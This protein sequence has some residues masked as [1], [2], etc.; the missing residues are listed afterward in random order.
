MPFPMKKTHKKRHS[1]E[2]LQFQNE[3]IEKVNNA[4]DKPRKNKLTKNASKK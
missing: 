1:K 4:E 3:Y 2:R